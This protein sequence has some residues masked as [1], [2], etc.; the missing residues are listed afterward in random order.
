M[1]PCAYPM[2]T[3]RVEP[4][5]TPRLG[6]L[7]GENEECCVTDYENLAEGILRAPGFA[8]ALTRAGAL[9]DQH[10]L[11]AI[12]MLRRRKELCACEIQAALGVTH[13]TVSHHMGVLVEAGLVSAARRGKWVYYSLAEGAGVKLP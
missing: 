9:S 13:A 11:L 6:R 10:R 4:G 12:A 1:L 5:L 2:S 7:S 3:A 8:I